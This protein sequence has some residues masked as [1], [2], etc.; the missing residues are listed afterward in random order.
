MPSHQKMPSSMRECVG[1]ECGG[2]SSAKCYAKGGRVDGAEKR[3]EREER[4]ESE[5]KPHGTTER[6]HEKG[7]Q[8]PIGKMQRWENLREL[9]DKKKPNLYAHGG[10]VSEHEFKPRE[11]KHKAHPEKHHKGVHESSRFGTKGA[12]MAGEDTRSGLDAK[13]DHRRVL[14]EMKSMK[15]PKLYA[16]GGEV[17]IEVHAEP[18]GDEGIEDELRGALGGELMSA[19]ERKDR[20]G[21]MSA[22]EAI[23]LSCRDKE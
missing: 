5:G 8:T 21:I 19:L 18:D 15:K 22:L 9:K 1:S 12:S 6:F 3:R 10:E 20:S 13:E 11:T 14:H 17:E 4:R 2:C 7:K 16:E 23:V